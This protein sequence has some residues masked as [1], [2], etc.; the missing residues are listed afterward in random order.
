MPSTPSDFIK[1]ILE[2]PSE[3]QTIEFKR[4]AEDRVVSKIIETVVAMTN[5]DGGVIVLGVDDPEKTKQK[6]LDRIYGIDENIEVFDATGR[7]MQK[8][9][10]PLSG[11]WPPYIVDVT[12]ISKR[13]ALISIPKAVDSFRSINN[14]VFVRQEKGNRQ[15]T[16]HEIVKFAYAKGFEKADKGLVEV[17]LELLKTTYF[18]EWKQARNINGSLVESILE[19]TGLARK[20]DAGKLLPT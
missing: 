15:L 17:P 1:D 14:H 8:I 20:S 6:G 10:P 4:L 3:S 13:I 2:I 19:K 11:L 18:E 5:T 12:E 9:V 16:A 7:E